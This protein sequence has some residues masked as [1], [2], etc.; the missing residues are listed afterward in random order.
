MAPQSRTKKLARVFAS[1][2]LS[3]TLPLALGACSKHSDA[4]PAGSAGST[5]GG[6]AGASAATIPAP[7][8]AGGSSPSFGSGFEGA[9][10][11]HTS[12]AK[13][14]GGEDMLFLT[15]GGKLRIDAPGRDGTV[16]HSI[17]DPTTQKITVLMD[18]QELAM[19]MPVPAPN[20]PGG[21]AG[22][23]SSTKLART[24]KHETIA[25]F[26]CEDWEM[27]LANGNRESTCVAQGLSFFDFSA[28]AGPTGGGVRSW[29]EELRDKNGFP[30]RALETDPSGKEISRM[31]VTKIQKKTLDDSIFAVPANF[32][33][34]QVP[35]MGAA[36]LH[37]A[38]K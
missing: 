19:Q 35:A 27:T 26:D 1:T 23:T 32:H 7:A 11:M 31:E 14:G 24:G 2:L 37:A 25:G 20:M 3:V 17:F 13:Q 36:A 38:H 15:K 8:A 21:A 9:I 5:D 28:M 18:T 10:V 6:A 29:A 34:M 4:G 22:G 16:A 12:S 33:L 30:L